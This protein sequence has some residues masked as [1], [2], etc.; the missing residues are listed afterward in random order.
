MGERDSETEKFLQRGGGGLGS[1]IQRDASEPWVCGGGG[2]LDGDLSL[3]ERTD[4]V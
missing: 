2:G 4:D 3:Y 1:Q